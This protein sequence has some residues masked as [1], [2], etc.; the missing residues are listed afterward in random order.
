[1]RRLASVLCA[2]CAIVAAALPAAAVAQ[3]TPTHETFSFP[4]EF[5]GFNPCSGE[6]IVFSGRFSGAATT[7]QD[8]SGAIHFSA[9]QLLTAQGQ[10][11]FGNRYSFSD[12][13]ATSVTFDSD[14]APFIFTQSLVD[15]VIAQGNAP[16][17]VLTTT[18]HSTI[19]ANGTVTAVVSEFR[20]ECR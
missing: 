18:V 13:L 12:S 3:A 15:H 2:V 9:H 19:N 8:P 17:Y 4:Y 20:A 1:M 10:G 6:S 14:S 7:V 16:N 5:T 11:D